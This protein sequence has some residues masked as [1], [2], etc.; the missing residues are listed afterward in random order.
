MLAKRVRGEDEIWNVHV[1]SQKWNWN[2][3]MGI[4]MLLPQENLFIRTRDTSCRKGS[5]QISMDWWNPGVFLAP[6]AVSCMLGALL[7]SSSLRD[8]SAILPHLTIVAAI[9][10][11]WPPRLWKNRGGMV[12]LPEV[13]WPGPEG[14]HSPR[15]APASQLPPSYTPCCRQASQHGLPTFAVS[16][17]TG[18]FSLKW[19]FRI[20]SGERRPLEFAGFGF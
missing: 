2:S 14:A 12:S 18:K 16:T 6:A 4:S 15:P 7:G 10:N 8:G 13:F 17:T 19:G 5:L 3:F 9:L 1:A 20:L 11:V